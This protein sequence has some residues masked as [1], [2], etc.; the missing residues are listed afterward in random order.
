LAIE[1][2][3]KTENLINAIH[4]LKPTPHRLEYIKSNINILDDSYNSSLSSAKQAIQVLNSTYYKKMVV[5]PGIIEGGKNQFELNYKLGKILINLDYVI[6]IGQTNK[7]AILSGIKSQNFKCKIITCSSLEESK[8]Y[9]KLLSSNDC[10]LLLNDLPD[11]Y[12]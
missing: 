11:D 6:I 8:Q 3:I 4:T 1:L 12:N 9:F 2:N 7:K 5:T 10:L